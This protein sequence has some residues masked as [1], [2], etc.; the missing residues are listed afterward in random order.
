MSQ[1][2]QSN[3]TKSTSPESTVTVVV[4]EETSATYE[5]PLSRMRE[6]LLPSAPDEI[7]DAPYIDDE[8]AMAA[9]EGLE[10]REFSVLERTVTIEA[11]EEKSAA[12][13]LG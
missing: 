10:P 6:L 12:E 7:R 3:G 9:L 13:G 5:V 2:T 8:L 11:D 1:H 4:R